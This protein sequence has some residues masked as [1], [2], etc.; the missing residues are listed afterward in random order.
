MEVFVC[1][2]V[3]AKSPQLCLILCNAMDSSLLGSLVH[4]ILEARI[5]ELFPPPGDLPDPGFKPVSLT[6][7]ALQGGFYHYHHH[8]L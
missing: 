8:Y 4:M 5:L 7:P 1:A 2:C 6:N 3:P